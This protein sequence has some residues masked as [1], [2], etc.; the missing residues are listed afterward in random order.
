MTVNGQNDEGSILPYGGH[1]V[2]MGHGYILHICVHIYTV[3]MRVGGRSA[4][5]LVTYW[6]KHF[7]GLG[8]IAGVGF[9]RVSFAA[10]YTFC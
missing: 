4:I 5:P 1:P 6:L 3:G 10:P 7:G 8:S 9:R 2:P